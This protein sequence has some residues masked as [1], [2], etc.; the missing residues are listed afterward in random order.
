MICT[1]DT[2]F[3]NFRNKVRHVVYFSGLISE[4]VHFKPCV[5]CHGQTLDKC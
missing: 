5:C 2:L 1:F 3:Y 4:Y